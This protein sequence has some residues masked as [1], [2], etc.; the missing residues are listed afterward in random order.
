MLQVLNNTIIKPLKDY[1]SLSNNSNLNDNNNN[2]SITC[3]NLNQNDNDNNN[4]KK[5]TFKDFNGNWVEYEEYNYNNG[6]L[7]NGYLD[8]NG[9]FRSKKCL[10]DEYENS[11]YDAFYDR[12]KKIFKFIEENNLCKLNCHL[13][14]GNYYISPNNDIYNIDK[15]FHT[16]LE[17][18]LDHSNLFELITD[19]KTIKLLLD[20]EKN[21]KLF[22]ESMK[23]I[24]KGVGIDDIIRDVIVPKLEEQEQEQNKNCIIC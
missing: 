14:E 18:L 12:S 16:K 11:R 10:T 4:D 24:D 19:E 5:E 23:D 2:E 6:V 21:K 22:E 20:Y 7:F 13:I 8:K 1:Y 17:D 9:Y 3:D 15:T